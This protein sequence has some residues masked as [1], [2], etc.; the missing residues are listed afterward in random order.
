MSDKHNLEWCM[1]IVLM[2]IVL[3]LSIAMVNAVR[4]LPRELDTSPGDCFCCGHSMYEFDGAD[5]YSI[6][7][8]E[9]PVGCPGAGFTVVIGK[10]A[11]CKECWNKLGPDERYRYG[12]LKAMS[13]INC[14]DCSGE[15]L[16]QELEWLEAYR[17]E[18]YGCWN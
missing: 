10:A 8:S 3:I 11:I 1:F 5:P 12:L 9:R 2:A 14:P 6:Y 4:E 7:A 18:A 17:K 15:L 16:Q 13:S